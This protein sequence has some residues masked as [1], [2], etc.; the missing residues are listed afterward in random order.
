MLCFILHRPI[1]VLF[2]LRLALGSVNVA[3]AKGI[4]RVHPLAQELNRTSPGQK[5]GSEL[6]AA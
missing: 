3:Q 5:P 1:S 4:E 2:G 6:I